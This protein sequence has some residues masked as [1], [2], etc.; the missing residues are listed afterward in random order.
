MQTH[1][2]PT[3]D[4]FLYSLKFAPLFVTQPNIDDVCMIDKYMSSWTRRYYKCIREN[5]DLPSHVPLLHT[6]GSITA[7]EMAIMIIRRNHKRRKHTNQK[8]SKSIS[9]N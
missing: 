7:A 1:E 2:E 9:R 6:C 4:P 8:K 3:K 5:P